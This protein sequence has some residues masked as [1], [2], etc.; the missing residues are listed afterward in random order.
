MPVR[1]IPPA[2]LKPFQHELRE[3]FLERVRPFLALDRQGATGGLHS[4]ATS[5]I[6]FA[7]L[8]ARLPEELHETLAQLEA[9]C[10]QRRQLATQTRLYHWLHGWLVLVHIPAAAALLGLIVVHIAAS[11][12]W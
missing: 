2:A 8:A 11:L 7:R 12:Y 10:A 3:F 9:L 4:D 5:T 6:V 1:T